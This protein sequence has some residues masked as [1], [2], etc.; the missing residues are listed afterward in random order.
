[1]QHLLGRQVIHEEGIVT[2]DEYFTEGRWEDVLDFVETFPDDRPLFGVLPV[3]RANQDFTVVIEHRDPVFAD[4]NS[5]QNIFTA[6]LHEFGGLIQVFVELEQYKLATLNFV[7]DQDVMG[8]LVE[9]V[10][11]YVGGLVKQHLFARC[12]NLLQRVFITRAEIVG[13]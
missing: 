2:L 8:T 12:L 4:E 11:V 3:K 7:V 13:N 9:Q 1:M 5:S 10:V 6:S